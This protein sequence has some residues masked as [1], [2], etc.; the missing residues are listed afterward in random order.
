MATVTDQNK[1]S[2]DDAAGMREH[3][4]ARQD[5]EDRL[6]SQGQKKTW[7]TCY[8]ERRKCHRVIALL[9]CLQIIYSILK[10]IKIS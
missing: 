8:D 4:I 3:G 6:N 2:Y 9:N 7:M 10:S 1:I 5:R